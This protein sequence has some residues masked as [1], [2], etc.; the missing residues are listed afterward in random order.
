MNKPVLVIGGSDPTGGAGIQTDLK[1]LALAGAHG[2]TVITCATTQNTSEF[3][4]IRP[5]PAEDIIDQLDALLDDVDF[6][7]AKLGLLGSPETIRVVGERLKSEKLKLIVDPVLSFTLGE[8]LSDDVVQAYTEHILPQTWTLTPNKKE[9]R[10]FTGRGDCGRP[11]AESVHKLGPEHVLITGGFGDPRTVEVLLTQGEWHKFRSPR[12]PKEVHGTGCT[13]TSLFAGYL[14]RGD[15]IPDAVARAKR[16]LYNR[17]LLPGKIGKGIEIVDLVSPMPDEKLEIAKA[18][19]RYCKT[20]PLYNLPE[21]GSNISYAQPQAVTPEEIAALEGRM[22]KCTGGPRAVGCPELG[23]SHHT[24]RIVLAVMHHD[25]SKRCAINIKYRPELVKRAGQLGLK[26]GTFKREDEP[27]GHKSM[28]W[29]THHAIKTLGEV[30][31]IIY[32][33]GGMGKEPMIR[34]IARSPAEAMDLVEK[35][36]G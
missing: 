12:L 13:F 15:S 4:T 24:A 1:A 3:K 18:V 10:R 21:V 17:M 31:D 27:P 34:V 9:A 6:E 19:E 25:P 11:L 8:E 23:G 22:V 14:A 28:E 29:G 7:Y 33:E 5:L 32:D 35:L 16:M 26:I 36:L 30:P 2:C 20:V